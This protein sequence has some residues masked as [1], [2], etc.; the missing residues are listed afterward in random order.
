[1]QR[2]YPSQLQWHPLLA[3]EEYGPGKWV[4]LAQY[5]RPYALIALIRRGDEIGY[6][7]T[8]WAKEPA[9]V[10]VVGYFRKLRAAA[11]AGHQ[12]FV[13]AHSSPGAR[14]VYQGQPTYS[15]TGY[16]TTAN[17]PERTERD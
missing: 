14:G 1:M 10:E 2:R 8:T 5:R 11:A 12:Q 16:S 15:K 3:C 9:E 7:V 13:T 4:M 17:T 6:R